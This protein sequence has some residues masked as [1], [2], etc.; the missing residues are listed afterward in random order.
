MRVTGFPAGALCARPGT[1]PELWFPDDTAPDYPA[2]VA[3]ARR[4]C[5]GC[6]VRT[7]CLADRM[8]SESTG[9]RF[10]V[11]AGTTPEERDALADPARSRQADA[12]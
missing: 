4:V 5:A 11:A 10:G 7:A 1:D 9:S 8:R 2:R 6:P 3:A 12:A